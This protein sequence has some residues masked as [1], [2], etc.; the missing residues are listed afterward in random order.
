MKY[1]RVSTVLQ[2]FNG[3]PTSGV[4]DQ[5]KDRG[6]R[7]H[8][9]CGAVINGYGTWGA[10]PDVTGYAESFAKWWKPEYKVIA[11]E[12]RYFCDVH[13]LTG[14][15]DLIVEIEGKLTLIDIKTSKSVNKTWPLQMS[16]YTMLAG[17]LPIV[18]QAV[19]QV[20]CDGTMPGYL[21][22]A[23]DTTGFL[24]LYKVYKKFFYKKAH[25]E[26]ERC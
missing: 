8:L 11:H 23:I 21:E 4:M 26:V 13:E 20:K 17:S 18:Q 3:Y 22:Y 9:A 19:L 12:Q 14:Q 1:I 15:V 7:A 10:D 2:P 16:A 25:N 6:T 24:D 5:Y